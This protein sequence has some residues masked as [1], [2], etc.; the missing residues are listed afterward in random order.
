MKIILLLL[1][2]ITDCHAAALVRE[3]NKEYNEEVIAE[4]TPDA[5]ISGLPEVNRVD[6]KI[7]GSAAQQLEAVK[8][9]TRTP[10]I[11]IN[12]VHEDQKQK[13]KAGRT[14]DV[15]TTH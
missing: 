12:I 2:T 11:I 8:A 10:Q 5:V 6:D 7:T 3:A 13:D 4:L 1:I 14:G 15:K 9:A